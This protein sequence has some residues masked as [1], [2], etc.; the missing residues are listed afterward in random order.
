MATGKVTWALTIMSGPPTEYAGREFP[1][2]S[3]HTEKTTFSANEHKYMQIKTLLVGWDKALPF[4]AIDAT[5]ACNVPYAGL[6]LFNINIFWVF[7]LRV[8]A[9]ICGRI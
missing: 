1:A 5:N 8:F 4:P 6:Q 2:N 9:F 3:S 7:N